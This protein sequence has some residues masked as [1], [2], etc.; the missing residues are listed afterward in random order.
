MN[1]AIQAIYNSAEK[2]SRRAARLWMESAAMVEK[3]TDDPDRRDDAYRRAGELGEK[4]LDEYK[5]T[6]RSLDFLKRYRRNAN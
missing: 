2:H 3:G 1:S 6:L 5:G 4:A